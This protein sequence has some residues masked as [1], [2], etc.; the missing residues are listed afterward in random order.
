MQGLNLVGL[1]KSKYFYLN[2][3]SD[4]GK[5]SF[6]TNSNH[7]EKRRQILMEKECQRK[8]SSFLSKIKSDTFPVKN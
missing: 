1:V 8:N 7:F 2:I 4:F 3:V 6:H 5:R